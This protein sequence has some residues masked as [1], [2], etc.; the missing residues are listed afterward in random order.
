MTIK[1]LTL[2]LTSVGLSDLYHNLPVLKIRSFDLKMFIN[3]EGILRNS[4]FKFSII[5][6]PA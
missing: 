3:A 4:A 6:L 2:T 1:N 5:L